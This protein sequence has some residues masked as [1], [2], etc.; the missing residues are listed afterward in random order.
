MPKP[1]RVY[2]T[3]KA[4]QRFFKGCDTFEESMEQ[5]KAMGLQ[6]IN[7]DI[8]ICRLLAFTRVTSRFLEVDDQ[9]NPGGTSCG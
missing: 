2:Y 6:G 7:Y 4:D 8:H 1:F 9:G 5:A 3:T